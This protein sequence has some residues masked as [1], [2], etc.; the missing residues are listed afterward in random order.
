MKVCKI[1]VVWDYLKSYLFR[2]NTP[3]PDPKGLKGDTVGTLLMGLPME[4]FWDY[5]RQLVRC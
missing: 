5:H 2:L 4:L 3:Y 1:K